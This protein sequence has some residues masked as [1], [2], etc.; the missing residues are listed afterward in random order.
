MRFSFFGHSLYVFIG[1][2]FSSWIFISCGIWWCV[3]Y[4]ILSWDSNVFFFG[5]VDD[6]E[7]LIFG[8]L[9]ILLTKCRYDQLILS[10]CRPLS[11]SSFPRIQLKNQ[12]YNIDYIVVCMYVYVLA[13]TWHIY[14]LKFV[15]SSRNWHRRIYGVCKFVC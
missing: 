6:D 9:L 5:V 3:W 12:P 1:G 11:S 15:N 2:I 14:W 13:I 8:F 10:F 4:T 7:R